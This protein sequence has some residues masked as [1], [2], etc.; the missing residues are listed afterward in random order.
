L[1]KGCRQGWGQKNFLPLTG[2]GI[3]HAGRS[4]DELGFRASGGDAVMNT[5]HLRN[6]EKGYEGFEE[7]RGIEETII[8]SGGLRHS[9]KTRGEGN[10]LSKR[11]SS[12]GEVRHEKGE[13]DRVKR[14]TGGLKN[15]KKSWEN[16]WD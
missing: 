6:Q 11:K 7:K 8:L 12:L 15:T 10:H 4:R 16:S 9:Q 14:R 13:F 3:I 5:G 2:L 1:K